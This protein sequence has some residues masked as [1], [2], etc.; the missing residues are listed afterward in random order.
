MTPKTFT[1]KNMNELSPTNRKG[2]NYQKTNSVIP[3]QEDYMHQLNDS[4][5][6]T[7][8][9][10][11]IKDNQE[12]KREK[13]GERNINKYNDDQGNFETFN[14]NKEGGKITGNHGNGNDHT[15]NHGNQAYRHQNEG[16]SHVDTNNT[17]NIKKSNVSL[18]IE[19]AS[20]GLHTNNKP[21]DLSNP[22]Q[23]DEHGN[24]RKNS[25]NNQPQ[26]EDEADRL[27][28]IKARLRK[29]FHLKLTQSAFMQS[30]NEESKVYIE[31]E[32]SANEGRSKLEH[33]GDSE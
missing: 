27:K 17:R 15:I 26:E 1:P 21:F 22:S 12:T 18:M 24:I 20:P 23:Y 19:P 3:L 5:E 32:G 6:K 29:D 30:K 25:N 14:A 13:A 4:K 31:Y 9:N 16:N 7:P 33:R 8:L 28:I 10:S 11:L 2:R